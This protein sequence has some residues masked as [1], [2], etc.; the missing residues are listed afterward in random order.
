MPHHMPAS[1]LSLALNV[2]VLIAVLSST[3]PKTA[4]CAQGLVFGQALTAATP[5]RG[6]VTMLRMLLTIS[7]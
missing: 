5:R 3:S 6:S 2:S 7:E 4:A 1:Y